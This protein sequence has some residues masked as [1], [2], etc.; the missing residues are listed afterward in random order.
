MHRREHPSTHRAAASWSR[1][2]SVSLLA[3]QRTASRALLRREHGS[4]S[5]APCACPPTRPGDTPQQAFKHTCMANMVCAFRRG[6]A[7]QQVA[8]ASLVC[9]SPLG[10]C[11]HACSPGRTRP[12]PRT[13]QLGSG[14]RPRAQAA[15]PRPARPPTSTCSDPQARPYHAPHATRRAHEQLGR[16]RW[17]GREGRTESIM[18]ALRSAVAKGA[19]A[20][21]MAAMRAVL[22]GARSRQAQHA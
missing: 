8:Q 15:A 21:Q 10:P 11:A 3:A 22:A 14:T 1:Y 17:K 7:W 13:W 5:S 16:A 19:H 12:G 2:H 6:G 4:L 20:T 9:A 18:H